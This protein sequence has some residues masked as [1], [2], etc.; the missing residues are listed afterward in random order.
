MD[1]LIAAAAR[2]LA[3]GATFRQDFPPELVPILRGQPVAPL[4]A[5][6]G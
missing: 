4:D 2:A 6:V 5:Y 3:A 1:S